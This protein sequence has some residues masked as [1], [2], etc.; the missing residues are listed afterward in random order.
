L[1]SVHARTPNVVM[2]LLDDLGFAQFGCYGSDIATPHID[3]LA[4][5]GLRYNRFH[6]TA[7]C[8]PT[9][10]ALLT[11]RNHHAVGMGFVADIPTSAPGYTARIPSSVPTLPRLLRDAGWNTMAVGKWH[12]ARTRDTT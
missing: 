4:A 12:L 1:T 3:R 7:M 5:N 2:I 10:A 6:V 8:S 11:G 9:R